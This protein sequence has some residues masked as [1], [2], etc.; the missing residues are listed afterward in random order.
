M[1]TLSPSAKTTKDNPG[2]C[3]DR[4]VYLH[5]YRYPL[6]DCLHHLFGTYPLYYLQLLRQVFRLLES[7]L[8]GVRGRF[9]PLLPQRRLLQT[10]NSPTQRAHWSS[11]EARIPLLPHLLSSKREKNL[12]LLGLQHLHIGIRPPLPLGGQMHRK[13]EYNCLL[14]VLDHDLCQHCH[15]LC[16]N[17]NCEYCQQES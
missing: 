15:Q 10:G 7:C 11:D 6:S 8:S 13:R 17:R 14:R 4:I 12:T 5:L 1:A 3:L 16:G 9:H 2:T